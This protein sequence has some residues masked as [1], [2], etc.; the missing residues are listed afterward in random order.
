MSLPILIVAMATTSF[1]LT[2]QHYI[3]TLEN[4]DRDMVIL[5]IV[6][7]GVIAGMATGLDGMAILLRVA[8]WCAI[9]AFFLCG[10][11]LPPIEGRRSTLTGTLPAWASTE[12]KGQK[13][14]MASQRFHDQDCAD[15]KVG[16]TGE[17][18]MQDNNVASLV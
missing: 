18:D 15:E 2:A 17:T 6:G 4:R 3:L 5:T 16:T 9:A 8:P 13:S 11:V 14:D 10:F 12:E 7:T 1:S